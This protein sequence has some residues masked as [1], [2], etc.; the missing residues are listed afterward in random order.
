MNIIITFGICY[1]SGPGLGFV[2]YPQALARLPLPQFWSVLFFLMLITVGLDSQVL[3][4]NDEL[5]VCKINEVGC[6]L[7]LAWAHMY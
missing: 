7:L 3:K 5:S 6:Q 4:I 2:A 1:I